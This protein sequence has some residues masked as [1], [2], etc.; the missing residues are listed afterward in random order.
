M[1]WRLYP[2]DRDLGQWAPCWDALNQSLYGG[3]PLYDSRFMS[4]LLRHFGRGRECL[5][6]HHD[7]ERADG[8]LILEPYRKGWYATFRPS[9]AQVCPVLVE[10]SE[11]LRSIFGDLGVAI[12]AID[13]LCQDPSYSPVQDSIDLKRTGSMRHAVTMNIELDGN[14]E[15]YW[16]GRSRKLRNNMR[17]YQKRL[18][19]EYG[20]QSVVRTTSPRRMAS[21]VSR[22]SDLEASGWKA[23]A[24]TAVTVDGEQGRF[25]TAVLASFAETNQASVHE[26][27]VNGKVIGSRFLLESGRIIIALKTAYDEAFAAFAPGR[28]LLYR[29]LEK[30]FDDSAGKSLEF[31]TNATVDQLSWATGTR[32]IRHVTVYRNRLVQL[33]HQGLGLGKRAVAAVQKGPSR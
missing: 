2:L 8:M 29:V 3:H 14:F 18:Q 21:A 19:S 4:A 6:V 13:L 31:Y 32:E 1:S 9:Q 20:G 23:R 33:G 22:Y 27:L 24:G 15:A 5:A 25:Y 17:R 16:A 7:G 28:L 10:S 11:L 12:Q 30:E 26:Y